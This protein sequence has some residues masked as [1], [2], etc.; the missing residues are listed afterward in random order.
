MRS[1]CLVSIA[2]SILLAGCNL[3][4]NERTTN[5]QRPEV[6]EETRTLL[7][8][9]QPLI[10]DSIIESDETY[11]AIPMTY[12][13]YVT[14]TEL[15]LI[16][17]NKE[18]MPMIKQ[19]IEDAV[20]VIY[21]LGEQLQ[22]YAY[23]EYNHQKYD[24]GPIGY[25]KAKNSDFQYVVVKALS[26]S[27]IK[28][29]GSLG[30]NAPHTIYIDITKERPAALIISAHTKEFD[31]N[32][33]GYNEIVASVGSPTYSSLYMLNDQQ[34]R[35]LDFNELLSAFLVRYD[36]IQNNFVVQFETDQPITRW[37]LDNESFIQIK[38]E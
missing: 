35:V 5:T 3:E 12:S 38:E 8:V 37:K 14:A 16:E 18:I 19:P 27:W 28:V 10:I 7:E 29:S 25:G 6:I 36:D 31:V 30:V 32:G 9:E 20:V 13:K 22:L 2:F 17:L 11:E 34:I 4:G 26:N 23:L 15:S 1:V 21:S 24:L 33:D